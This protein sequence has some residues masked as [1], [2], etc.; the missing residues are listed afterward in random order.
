MFCCYCAGH[1]LGHFNLGMDILQFEDMFL[2]VCLPLVFT[3]LCFHWFLE[4]LLFKF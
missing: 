3:P 4:F 2:F 1:L